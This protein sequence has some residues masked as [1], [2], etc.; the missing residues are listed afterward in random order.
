MNS[1]CV[2]CEWEG[3]LGCQ[4]KCLISCPMKERTQ[5]NDMCVNEWRC[6]FHDAHMLS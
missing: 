6:S 5:T 1:V 4:S 2:V 3:Q